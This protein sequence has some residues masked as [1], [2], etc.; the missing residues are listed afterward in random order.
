MPRPSCIRFG[1]LDEHRT[2]RRRRSW[3]VF[4]YR[5]REAFDFGQ[6]VMLGIAAVVLSFVTR[7]SP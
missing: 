6:T 7:D 3:R 2:P 1:R 4:A 5:A